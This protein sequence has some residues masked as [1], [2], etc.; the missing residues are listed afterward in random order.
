MAFALIIIQ[1][2]GGGAMMTIMLIMLMMMILVAF[3]L[4]LS[5]Y[6]TTIMDIFGRS[7]AVIYYD[8]YEMC[9]P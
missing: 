1:L 2:L 6:L 4:S 5:H 9:N 7:V 8:T 3:S